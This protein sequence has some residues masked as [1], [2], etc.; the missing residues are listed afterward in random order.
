MK[1]T[2]YVTFFGSFSLSN[3]SWDSSDVAAGRG[4]V[5]RR[6]WSFLQYLCA[7][8]QKGASQEELIEAVWGEAEITDPVGA[9]KMI[10]YRAR[11]L[12]EKLGFPDGKKI[13]LYRQGRYSWSSDVEFHLDTEELD[14]LYAEFAA[15]PEGALPK[16]LDFLPRY[17]GDF[18]INAEG[19]SWALSLRTFY[20]T[21]YLQMSWGAANL[22]RTQGRFSEAIDICR[23]ATTLDPYD[24][25]CQLLLIRL[26][27][28]SGS[29]HTALQHYSAVS[30][31]YMDQLGVSPS[32]GML[33][34]YQEISKADAEDELELSTVRDGLLEQG[35]IKGPVF[36]GY[37][38]FQDIYRL[39]A[40]TMP[41]TG[42]VAQ[43]A[44]LT[45]TENAGRPLDSRQRVAAMD[46]LRDSGLTA[47]RPGDVVARVGPRQVLILL[48]SADRGKA[49]A[50]LHR[51][52]TAFERTLIGKKVGIRTSL[53]P[54]LPAD[55]RKERE[56]SG[57]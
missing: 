27:Y 5:S 18:L 32:P 12:V 50:A 43:L 1:K 10:L 45:I 44:L 51:I 7:F 47:L 57:S 4:T 53:L 52:L 9:L 48:S 19:N 39:I 24:E 37:A 42:D 20:H 16:V 36:C 15:A 30:E 3:S 8:H 28:S 25:R 21:R 23:A 33:A 2:L 46:A 6:L 34:L 22:L 31:L 38:A 17:G 29:T 40:R 11:M 26:L 14:R 56:A 41:R 35:A 54:V 49:E 55:I 13:L